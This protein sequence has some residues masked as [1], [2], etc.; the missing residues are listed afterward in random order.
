MSIGRSRSGELWVLMRARR[1]G[2]GRNP[3][4]RRVDR[5]ESA[6]VLGAVLAALLMIP[7]AAATGTALR[8]ASDHAAAHRRAVLTQVQART[9]EDTESAPDGTGQVDT[10]VRVTWID[11]AGRP[12]EGRANVAFGTKKDAEVIVWLDSSGAITLPPRPAGD[13][14]AIGSAVGLSLAMVSWLL[15]A[16]L[17]RLSVVPLNRRR[18]RAWEREWEIVAPRWRHRQG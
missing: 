16:G 10:T 9:L 11:P 13:S 5:I 6:I 1:L 12:H 15:I 2:Y 14:A 8:N 4:R 17:A 18:M 7:I 3:L